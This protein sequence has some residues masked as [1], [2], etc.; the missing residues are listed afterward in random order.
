MAPI[1]ALAYKGMVREEAAPILESC[2]WIRECN[3]I[4]KLCHDLG[5]INDNT[6][7]AM[8]S[9]CIFLYAK[10]LNLNLSKK[11]ISDICKIS[12]VTINKCY[13]KLEIIPEI[14]EYLSKV[15]RS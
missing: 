9:G 7:P 14:N 4:S 8:A 10:D 5:L 1:V 12:E 6:P 13:K 3:K 11:D 2:C 15:D